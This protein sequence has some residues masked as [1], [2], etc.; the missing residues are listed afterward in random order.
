MPSRIPIGTVKIVRVVPG[1]A[2]S[3]TCHNRIDGASKTKTAIVK[4]EVIKTLQPR[5][6]ITRYMM[7]SRSGSIITSAV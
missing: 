4:T 3:L 6:I 1:G 5:Q 7:G 2:I